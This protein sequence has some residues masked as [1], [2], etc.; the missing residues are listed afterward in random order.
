MEASMNDT[1]IT[2]ET[3]VREAIRQLRDLPD[4]LTAEDD[5]AFTVEQA[6]FLEKRLYEVRALLEGEDQSQLYASVNLYVHD[7]L[8]RHRQIAAIWAVEDVK[9]IRPHLTDD[10]AWEVLE[11]VGRK[12]DA[13]YGISWTTLECVADDLFPVSDDSNQTAGE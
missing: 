8:A 2:L 3:R 13:E 4:S 5:P 7:L 1:N 6:N 11:Q 9:G 12:H 10:Q